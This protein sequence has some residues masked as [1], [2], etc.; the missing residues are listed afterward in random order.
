MCIDY[1]KLNTATRKD[2]FPLSFIDQMLERLVGHTYYCFLDGYSTYNQIAIA[3]EDQ[4]RQLSHVPMIHSLTG[5]CL[6]VYT[7]NQ[8]YFKGA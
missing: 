2:H 1:K 7:M 5:E 4:E 8:L 3:L 6:L